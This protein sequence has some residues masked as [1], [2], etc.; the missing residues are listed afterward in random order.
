MRGSRAF[1]VRAST[2]LGF[3]EHTENMFTQ[4]YYGKKVCARVRSQ[5]PRSIPRKIRDND[6]SDSSLLN[7]QKSRTGK[8]ENRNSSG[9]QE[10]QRNGI[11]R[12]ESGSLGFQDVPKG[13][14]RYFDWHASHRKNK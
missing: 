4:C 10:I 9:E 3:L 8:P 13:T 12:A 6:Q 5:N 14:Q 1:S 7:Q 11:Q 2:F